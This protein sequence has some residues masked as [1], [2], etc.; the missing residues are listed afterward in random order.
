MEGAH[1]DVVEIHPGGHAR[2]TVARDGLRRRVGEDVAHL[3][4]HRRRSKAVEGGRRLRSVGEGRGIQHRALS[5]GVE[6]LG[7]EGLGAEGLGAEELD[8]EG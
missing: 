8:A 5:K 7:A 2:A 6:G 3:Q 1:R 4:M